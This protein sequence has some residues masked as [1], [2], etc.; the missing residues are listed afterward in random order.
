MLD[1]IDNSNDFESLSQ[2]IVFE[3]VLQMN[4]LITELYIKRDFTSARYVMY[5]DYNLIGIASSLNTWYY[6]TRT[7]VMDNSFSRCSIF[8]GVLKENTPRTSP[9]PGSSRMHVLRG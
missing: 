1:K 5:K 6:N 3:Y 2:Y 8:Y 4:I 7:H 9:K